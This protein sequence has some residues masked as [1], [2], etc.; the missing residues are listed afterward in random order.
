[1]QLRAFA[2]SLESMYPREAELKSYLITEY[3]PRLE[4]EAE[5]EARNREKAMQLEAAQAN[6]RRSSRCEDLAAAKEEEDRKAEIRQQE[7]EWWAAQR[8][9]NDDKRRR[10]KEAKADKEA[11]K[12]AKLR[13]ETMKMQCYSQSEAEE[14]E[15]IAISRSL[16]DARMAER[17][18]RERGDPREV[19]AGDVATTMPRVDDHIE[20][21]WV[22]MGEW[23]RGVV[24]DLKGHSTVTVFYEDGEK[25]DECLSNSNWRHVRA[26]GHVKP[27]YESPSGTTTRK[28]PT[29]IL[30]AELQV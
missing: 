11:K 7:H 19:A 13:K 4:A 14:A 27:W 16:R 30:K 21:W 8:K 29:P 5:K 23:Y 20:V 17:A 2:E 1:M 18:L 26:N 25:W 15:R 24:I 9:A 3:I 22:D 6:R 12:E 28:A 10:E